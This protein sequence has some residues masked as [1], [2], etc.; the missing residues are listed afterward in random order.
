MICASQY[1]LHLLVS[2]GTKVLSSTYTNS[3]SVTQQVNSVKKRPNVLLWYT[4]DEYVP[5]PFTP[6]CVKF[7]NFK[8]THCRPDGTSDA[9]TAPQTTANLIN[10]LD[11]YHPV[12]LVLNCQ[13][14]YFKEY[15]TG[16]DIILQDTYPTGINATYSTVWGTPCTSDFGD[17]G[18]DNCKGDW[19][20]IS[21]RVDQFRERARWLGRKR[22]MP[23]WSVPQAFGNER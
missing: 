19:T 2:V 11:G 8:F 7:L 1:R 6:L 20:D 23:I 22:S 21:E 15:T 9:L 3:S 18:C 17:C 12:S 13:D 5:P 16:T 14:Y 10:S 4:G